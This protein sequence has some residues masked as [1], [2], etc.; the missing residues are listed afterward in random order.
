MVLK[1][2]ILGTVL[3]P[4]ALR[5]ANPII[6]DVF[7]AAP[8]VLVYK[9]T[10]YLYT[11]HD[12]TKPNQGYT[13]R[14]WLVFSSKDTK[15]WTA[16]GSPLAAKDFAWAKG[17][18]WASQVIERDGKF[19]WYATVQHNDRHRGKAI[20]VAMSDSPNGPFKDARGS[21]LITNDMKGGGNFLRRHRSDRFLTA[22]R[23]GASGAIR[24]AITPS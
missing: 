13:M 7:T 9:D 11:G 16:H 24:N 23:H 21:A 4:H 1:C 20:G 10:V 18:A 6:T 14:D 2:L 22:A 3:L 12:E 19:Y 17:D 15:T 5:A 8:V